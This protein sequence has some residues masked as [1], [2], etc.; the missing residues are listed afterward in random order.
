METEE[1]KNNISIEGSLENKSALVT[2]GTTGI[3][4]AI[5]RFLKQQGVRVYIVGSNPKHLA[6]AL[7]IINET[8]EKG[9]I[10]GIVADIGTPE[11]I[12]T[13]ITEADEYLD[14][15][16]ILVNNAALAFKSVKE[17]SY[18]D[19]SKVV[20]TNLTGYMAFSRYAI[21][22]MTPNKSGHIVNIGS[23]SADVREVNSSVYTATKSGIQ[24]FSE[25]LRKE[26]N[27]Q[28]IKV[29]LIEPGS[30]ATDMQ[31]LSTEEEISNQEKLEM[32]KAEDIAASVIYAL[33][34]PL[35]CEVVE[36]K[37]KP[38]MQII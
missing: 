17:G 11:G 37:I 29:T 13:V 35:R 32:L 18:E 12:K 6:E 33:S 16:D 20:N 9:S 36:M 24:G 15:L 14:K 5:A 28:G 10:D 23:M 31:E 30:V 27:E 22:R 26:I 38:H 19:W 21:D 2:G 34:L 25:S 8:T 4:R 1:Y 3:G 7:E